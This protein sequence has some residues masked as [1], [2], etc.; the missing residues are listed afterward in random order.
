MKRL[1]LLTEVDQN[2]FERSTK[3]PFFLN[4]FNAIRGLCNAV[5]DTGVFKL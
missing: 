2:G 4:Y 5:G 3:S 1:P